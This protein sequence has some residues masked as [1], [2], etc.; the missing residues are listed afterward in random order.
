MSITELKQSIWQRLEKMEEEKLTAVVNFLDS[1]DTSSSDEVFF[2]MA[3]LWENRDITI[4]S[5]RKEA[6]KKEI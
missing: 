5:I 3:G 6:W 4:D 1:L 2:S